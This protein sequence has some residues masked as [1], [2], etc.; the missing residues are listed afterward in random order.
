M[1]E[2]RDTR[3]RGEAATVGASVRAGPDG[4]SVRRARGSLGATWLSGL[5]LLLGFALRL[6]HLDGPVL[7]ADEWFSYR[8][9]REG[10]AWILEQARVFEP[11]PPT[12]YLLL[13]GWVH[14]AGTGE[15]A[16]R[17]PSVLVG[18][19]GVAGAAVLGRLVAG[20]WG[21]VLAALLLAVSPYQILYAQTA[22]NYALVAA[23]S[24]LATARLLVAWQRGAWRSY[25][26]A[27]VLA[28]YAHYS[29][30]LVQIGH[31]VALLAA[32]TVA[33]GAKGVATDERSAARRGLVAQAVVLL[34]WAPMVL[35]ALPGLLR[36]PG[37]YPERLPPP[38]VV[39]RTLRAFVVGPFALR[40][41]SV[42]VPA[43]L[44]WIEVAAPAVALL[45]ALA[46][47]IALLGRDPRRAAALLLVSVAPLLAVAVALYW[48]PMFEVRYFVVLAPGFLC[49][50]AAG[51]AEARRGHVALPIVGAILLS[52]ALVPSLLATYEG[53]RVAQVDYRE[54]T[55][56]MQLHARRGDVVVTTGHGVANLYGYY[57][58]DLPAPYVVADS[59]DVDVVLDAVLRERPTGVW[60]LP[61]AFEP[62]DHQVH[63][64]LASLGYP[65]PPR[66]FRNGR[67]QYVALGD[68]SLTHHAVEATYEGV[69]DLDAV[70]LEAGPVEPG[71]TV[72]VALRW[73][74]KGPASG[75]KLSLRLVDDAGNLV[76]QVDGHPVDDTKP[77][78]SL[79]PGTTVV[80]R[81][82]LPVPFGTLPGSLHVYLLLYDPIS[83]STVAPRGGMV[84]PHGLLLGSV[85]VQP[86]S[87]PPPLE[88]VEID[89]PARVEYGPVRFGGHSG[90][91]WTVQAGGDVTVALLWQAVAPISEPTT[92]E[93]LLLLDH[94]AVW[95]RTWPL[96]GWYPA[97][98]WRVGEPVVERVRLTTPADLEIGTYQLAVALNGGPPTPLG[99]VVVEGPRRSYAP[100]TP[101]RQIAARWGAVAELVGYDLARI[102]AGGRPSL[103]V[104]L[105][106]KA[107]G[108]TSTSYKT[109]VHLVDETGKLRAQDD[110]VPARGSRPTTG[111]R[112]GEYVA[113]AHDVSLAGVPPGR[114]AVHVGLY[115]ESGGERL[116]IA[117]GAPSAN[118][119]LVLTEVVLP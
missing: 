81:R 36:Y 82:G 64:R 78:A 95:R 72:R 11:H 66:W 85:E 110:A 101:E 74:V 114:Y 61:Y 14:V 2:D 80:D 33:S 109:F 84:S 67:A 89:R 34:A 115:R 60:F 116:P 37:Y 16:L 79:A 58:G 32:A 77:F 52:L 118:N 57:R 88:A 71:G 103:R 104:V 94:E 68:A 111:W 4:R 24:T 26:V 15:F 19:V 102:E 1:H 44:R 29:A 65:E 62:L 38:E 108:T 53:M 39:W 31:A 100:P 9:T 76:Q 54:M 10:P 92:A 47:V 5:V 41:E 113:D 22:R 86:A 55:R 42:G 7:T 35:Y 63:A 119:A 83:G 87:N 27:A 45:L 105:Y 48:R 96:G 91:P 12:Y 13:T 21:G 117:A 75:W 3:G 18:T 106:W 90:G 6:W 107:L 50:V 28:L 23:L 73:N 112:A 51:L 40:P 99:P 43:D 20:R 49:L 98:R 69:L 30:L 59:R 97:H 70:D 8:N 25:V 17:F 93:L 46:G 56:W